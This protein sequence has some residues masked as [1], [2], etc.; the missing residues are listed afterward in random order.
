LDVFNVDKTF[1]TLTEFFAWLSLKANTAE[2]LRYQHLV[3]EVN[4]Y[5]NTQKDQAIKNLRDFLRIPDLEEKKFKAFL[6]VIDG[7]HTE[8]QIYDA[9]L[10]T[11]QGKDKNAK[12]NAQ[13]DGV[14]VFW[15]G[16][17]NPQGGE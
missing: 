3:N 5:Y 11:E 1:G 12:M 9:V 13:F 7:D 17:P 4:G 16:P 8:Q 6:A 2:V 15:G 14:S 10:S